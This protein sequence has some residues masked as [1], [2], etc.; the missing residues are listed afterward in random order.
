MELHNM[1]SSFLGEILQT[2]RQYVNGGC[3]SGSD[4][5]GFEDQ[6]HLHGLFK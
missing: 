3:E 5:Q 6:L 4:V 1:M 2:G